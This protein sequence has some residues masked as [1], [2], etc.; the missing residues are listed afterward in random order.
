MSGNAALTGLHLGGGVR[1][2]QRAPR[3]ADV[4]AGRTVQL[5]PK[6]VEFII[7]FYLAATWPCGRGCAEQCHSTLAPF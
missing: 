6:H 1:G 7:C 2:A 3:M 5:Q 4:P